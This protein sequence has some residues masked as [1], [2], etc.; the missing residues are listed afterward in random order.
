MGDNGSPF[1]NN[2]NGGMNGNQN[3]GGGGGG[4]GGEGGLGPP[5]FSGSNF[6]PFPTS[7]PFAR[8]TSFSFQTTT[9]SSSSPTNAAQTSQTSASLGLGETDT[10]AA[11]QAGLSGGVIAAIII[12]IVLLLSLPLALFIYSRR[13]K[14][15]QHRKSIGAPPS[16]HLP[17]YEYFTARSISSNR[18]SLQ[19]AIL[20]TK[21]LPPNPEEHP[22]FRVSAPPPARAHLRSS[23]AMTER[24]MSVYSDTNLYFITSQEIGMETRLPSRGGDLLRKEGLVL[25]ED[26]PFRASRMQT[27]LSR[28]DVEMQGVREEDEEGDEEGENSFETPLGSPKFM[29]GEG[30]W[31]RPY[32]GKLRPGMGVQRALTPSA[33]EVV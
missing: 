24:S 15:R 2:G 16:S 11:T 18:N 26:N 13:R 8:P 25:E 31:R 23:L 33:E 7:S 27:R 22:T 20:D 10:P 14:L 29:I 19:S 17:L 4:G 6:P 3:N 1:S 30:K 5:P 9:S 32:K 28:I 21:P 12:L